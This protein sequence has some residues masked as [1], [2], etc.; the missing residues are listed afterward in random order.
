MIMS[1][2]GP[3]NTRSNNPPNIQYQEYFVNSTPI[4]NIYI[5]RA[6]TQIAILTRH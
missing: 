1:M 2:Q 4:S 3:L 6:K 5:Y